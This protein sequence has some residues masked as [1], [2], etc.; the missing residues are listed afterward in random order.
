MQ[1][2]RELSRKR[3]FAGS[4]GRRDWQIRVGTCTLGKISLGR[5]AWHRRWQVSSRRHPRAAPG[6]LLMFKFLHAADIHLDSPQRGLERYEGAPVAECRGATRRALENLVD[7]A[8]AEK[9][10]FVMIVGDLYDGDWPDYNTGLFFGKQMA[11]LRDAGI[12]VF[13]IRGNHDAANKMTKDL[14]LVDNVRVLSTHEAET[15]LLEDQRRGD[16]RPELRHPGRDGE[17]GEV[18]SHPAG[19][20]LQP[21]AAAHLCRRPRGARAVCPLHPGRPPRPGIPATGRWGTSIA[22]RSFTRT[23]PG[24]SSRETSRAGMRRETGPKGCM[25]VTVDDHHEVVAAEPRWLDVMRWETCPLD[26][27]RRPATA[28]KSWRAST[29]G[30]PSLWPRATTACWRCG[31]RFVGPRRPTRPWPRRRRTGPANSARRRSTPAPAASGSR[32]FCSGRPRRRCQL[33]RPAGDSPLRASWR[34]TWTSFA[35]TTAQLLA[36][37]SEPSTTLP[38]SSPPTWSTAWIPPQRL[39]GL[40]DQVGPLLLERL[41]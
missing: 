5:S 31:S 6:F 37:K 25:L 41:S 27:V 11:R 9:V 7:L 19:G 22:A 28:T 12:R 32:R 13:M 1:H 15:V 23:I 38:A 2:R 21:R 33:R 18:L 24:S 3:R 39:R 20:L 29:I 34:P 14:R 8:L 16:P 17:P 26:A 35:P 36:L 30:W 10:A 4:N 40:L